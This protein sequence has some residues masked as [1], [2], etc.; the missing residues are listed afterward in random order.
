[1]LL[2]SAALLP[3]AMM[4]VCSAPAAKRKPAVDPPPARSTQP[5]AY[6]IPAGALG[7]AS[8]GEIYLGS[9][10]SLVSLDFLDEDRLLF[11]FRVP[12]L[13]HRDPSGMAG[14]TERHIRAVVVHIPDGEVQA[15]A[16]WTLHDYGRY[17]FMLDGGKF[18]LRDR[19]TL[20]LGNGALVLTPWLHF[21]GPLQYVELDP[22]RQFLVT[23]SNEPHLSQAK[24]GDVPSP[25]TAQASIDTDAAPT[26]PRQDS[27]LRILRGSSGQVMLVSHVRN[28]THVPFNADGY[29][30]V[31]R[32]RGS[33]WLIQFNPFSGGNA[34]AGAVD[35]VCAPRLDF[36][37]PVEYVAT[38]CGSSG[39]PWVVAMTLDG[40]LLWQRAESATS[41]WPLLTV[42]RSGTRLIRETVQTTHP[43]N[44]ISPLSP[45]DI[46]RQDVLVLDAATGKE[47]LKAQASPVFDGGG[48][49]ALSPSGR[50]AAILMDGGIQIFELPEA[51]PLPAAKP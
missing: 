15:E 36:V 37:S 23:E 8:P 21:P 12:G 16:L 3:A 10:F 9:R 43:V 11:S 2:R 50:R 49:V 28:A 41:I 39:A 42:S 46:M 45:D 7:F 25:T 34:R 5:P 51:P 14:D 18:A 24:P 44:A 17:L 31:L 19:D 30:E 29:L 35:S 32:S 22:S 4:F 33:S 1:M 40:H 6:T 27:V 48:N 13:F 26:V 20:G 38:A 47:V